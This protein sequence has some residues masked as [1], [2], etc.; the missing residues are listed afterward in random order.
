MP[1]GAVFGEHAIPRQQPRAQAIEAQA[2]AGQKVEEI[3]EDAGG[4]EVRKIG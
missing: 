1:S 4:Y 2:D 3:V